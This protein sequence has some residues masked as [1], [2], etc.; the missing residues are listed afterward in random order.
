MTDAAHIVLK[1]FLGGINEGYATKLVTKEHRPVVEKALRLLAAVEAGTHKVVP[2]EPDE[3]MVYAA[4][5]AQEQFCDVD[6][7]PTRDLL[8]AAIRAAIYAAPDFF[9]EDGK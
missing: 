2:V 7:Y 8:K 3:C 6:V 1:E 5:L 4:D 9:G